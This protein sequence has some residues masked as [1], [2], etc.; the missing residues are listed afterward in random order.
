MDLTG[1]VMPMLKEQLSVVLDLPPFL[2]Q[3]VKTQNPMNSSW[4]RFG[5]KL[6]IKD[7]DIY[8]ESDM[9]TESSSSRRDLRRA[10]AIHCNRWRECP[11]CT[12]AVWFAVFSSPFPFCRAPAVRS[13]LRR[14]RAPHRTGWA[15][16]PLDSKQRPFTM[17]RSAPLPPADLSAKDR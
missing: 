11:H 17:S 7:A 15:A 12:V 8:R 6:S 16:S 13:K 5:G 14:R 2:R 10:G 4:M 1:T 3:T 9:C